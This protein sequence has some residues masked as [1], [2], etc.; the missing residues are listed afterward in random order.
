MKKEKIKIKGS[1]K[2]VR[3]D[4]E[5]HMFVKS[6]SHNRGK[7]MSDVLNGLIKKWKESASGDEIIKEDLISKETCSKV[8]AYPSS[9]RYTIIDGKLCKQ[10]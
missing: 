4:P 10:P 6:Y 9:N 5:L 8:D 2:L 7:K 1:V 3:I